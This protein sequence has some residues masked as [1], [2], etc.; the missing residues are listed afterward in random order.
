MRIALVPVVVLSKLML[1]TSA[2]SKLAALG[3]LGLALIA[4]RRRSARSEA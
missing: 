3:L 4:A 1:G 2:A